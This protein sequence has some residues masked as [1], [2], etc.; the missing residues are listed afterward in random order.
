M[1]PSIWVGLTLQNK[2][3]KKAKKLKSQGGCGVDHHATKKG[4]GSPDRKKISWSQILGVNTE[5]WPSLGIGKRENLSL[6][7]PAAS[8]H[9]SNSFPRVE[10]L[11]LHF[12]S[13]ATWWQTAAALH[14]TFLQA[15][16]TGHIQE[17]LDGGMKGPT[18]QL[19]TTS[20]IPMYLNCSCS[21][22]GTA[23]PTVRGLCFGISLVAKF[24]RTTLYTPCTATNIPRAL[25]YVVI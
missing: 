19:C 13:G 12:V 8:L 6:L 10:G 14:D 15:M 2:R 17:S 25:I 5:L 7:Q 22:A 24:T 9:S 21:A 1:K 4:K 16:E 23:L 20:S 3:L 18:Q 11:R